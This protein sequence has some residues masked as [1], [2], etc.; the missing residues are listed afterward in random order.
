MALAVS[1]FSRLF[2]STAN[3]NGV[4]RAQAA[5]TCLLSRRRCMDKRSASTSKL[6]DAK[7]S[8]FAEA[9]DNRC[10]NQLQLHTLQLHTP[11]P[12]FTAPAIR[13]KPHRGTQWTRH[14]SR[15]S[16]LKT[17]AKRRVL[18]RSHWLRELRPITTA[19]AVSSPPGCLCLSSNLLRST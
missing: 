5:G 13:T 18:P 2:A 9:K 17:C 4:L 3:G 11:G 16:S 14:K 8:R 1:K 12:Q 10:I 7:K 15:R 6:A 19:R